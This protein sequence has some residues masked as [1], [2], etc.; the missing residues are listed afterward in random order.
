MNDK[1]MKKL[2][3]F[4]LYFFM[5]A[6]LHAQNSSRIIVV[7]GLQREYIIH[8]PPAFETMKK[9]P[10]IVALHGG[11]STA[12]AAQRFYNLQELADKNNIIIVYPNAVN[13]AWSI[14]GMNSRVKDAD[15]SVKDVHFISVLLDTMI[16]GDKVDAAKVFVTGMS[17]GAMFSYWLADALNARIT[18]IAAVCGGISQTQARQYHFA[19]PI[20]VLMINGT[21][22][23][24]VKYEGGYGSLN[25]RNEGNE[26][27]DLLPTEEL[28]KKI[29]SLNQCKSSPQT[30]S[31]PDVYAKDGCT[32]T[33]MIYDCNP[34]KVDFIKIENGGHTWAG[35]T[36]Y[37]PKFLIGTLCKDFSASQ[38]VVEFF[39]SVK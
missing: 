26:D 37:L 9:L 19:K 3:L 14:P 1:T 21:A 28:L 25:K 11:G 7:D 18:A 35:G 33:E 22:D 32:E 20:P 31:L 24:L 12:T 27:A 38:K 5:S 6:C 10:L 15:T 30:L 13:K 2:S 23:P 17:R 39:M 36:Q 8:L 16:A 29:V 34:V 4:I